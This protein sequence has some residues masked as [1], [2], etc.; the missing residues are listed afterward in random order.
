MTTSFLISGSVKTE[1]YDTTDDSGRAVGRFEMLSD[2]Y[3]PLLIKASV[4]EGHSVRIISAMKVGDLLVVSGIMRSLAPASPE[5]GFPVL[6]VKVRNVLALPGLHT[7][8]AIS[9]TVCDH[10]Y[11]QKNLAEPS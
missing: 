8:R 9:E 4:A 7:R 5:G 2:D 3:Q 10:R 1:L 6:V 11:G